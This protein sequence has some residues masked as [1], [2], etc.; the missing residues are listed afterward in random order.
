MSVGETEDSTVSRIT[1]LA[2][3][4]E[5]IKDQII[6]QIGKLHDV[7]VVELMEPQKTVV[8]ELMLIKIH[9]DHEERSA[10]Q[11]AVS[12]FR[13]KVVDL[14]T[15]SMTVEITGEKDKLDAFLAFLHPY[16]V[17]ELCRTGIT[18]IGR[19]DYILTPNNDENKE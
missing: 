13:A 18:A 8:R 15:S 12:V 2:T 10:I 19:D 6:K 16:K 1:I 14:S 9:A 7:K 4:D 5:Y 3:G 11:E 17:S